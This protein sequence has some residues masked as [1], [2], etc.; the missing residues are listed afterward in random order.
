[1]EVA[2][3]FSGSEQEGNTQT[4]DGEEPDQDGSSESGDGR[5]VL[6]LAR[7]GGAASW[8]R[9]GRAAEGLPFP[10]PF[11]ASSG[12]GERTGGGL[13]WAWAIQ[14]LGSRF[15]FARFVRLQFF[16]MYLKS[17]HGNTCKIKY[18]PYLH[19]STMV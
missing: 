8:G 1:V 7:E 13:R 10:S 15:Q 4:T 11:L 19:T 6:G 2:K 14:E 16:F 3:S 17:S 12:R 18:M 5:G 9:C